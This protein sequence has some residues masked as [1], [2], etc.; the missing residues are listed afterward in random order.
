[1]GL[2]ELQPKCHTEKVALGL[3]Q[4]GQEIILAYKILET[5]SSNIY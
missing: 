5:V 1:M 2:E 4:S 3:D